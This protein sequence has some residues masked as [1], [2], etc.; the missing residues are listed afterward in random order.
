MKTALYIGR[1]QLFHKG[2]LE[3]LEHITETDD[4]SDVILGVGSSQYDHTNK[5]PEIPWAVNPFTCEERKQMIEA[6]LNGQLQ[7]PY[8][9][10]PIPDYHNCPKWIAHIKEHLPEFHVYY[11]VSQDEKALFEEHGYEVRDFPRNMKDDK[12]LVHAGIIRE[13]MA[14]GEE[15]KSGLTP[16]TIQVLEDINAEERMKDLFARDFAE[17]LR[18]K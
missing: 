4:I 13:R 5:S 9:V 18:I 17:S 2:H 6:S 11:T 14:K 8:Q 10:E 12:G 7:K 3:V 15:Y 16:G 1:F